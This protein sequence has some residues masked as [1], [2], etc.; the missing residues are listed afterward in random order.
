MGRDVTWDGKTS[1]VY[2]GKKP[3]VKP[4]ITEP[5]TVNVSTVDE[6]VAALGSNKV[7]KLQPGVYNLSSV[8]ER[9]IR[10]VFRGRR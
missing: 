9:K 1:S 2:I 3:V 10:T 8:K 5:V 7:I 6:L 4:P